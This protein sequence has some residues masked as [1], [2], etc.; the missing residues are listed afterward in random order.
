MT[1]QTNP[2]E[3]AGSWYVVQC[4]C[5]ME[6]YAEAFLRGTLG[7][8]TYLPTVVSRVH[9]VTKEIPF[10]PGYLFVNAALDEVKLS[11]INTTPGVVR[12]VEFGGE[13]CAVPAAVVSALKERLD[14]LK[15]QG[16]LP[17]HNFRLGDTV[18]VKRGPLAGLQAIFLGPTTPG[19]R[20][21]ILLEFLGRPNEV[22]VDVAA[23]TT[24][25]DQSR[26]RG[27][28]RTRGSGRSI[29]SVEGL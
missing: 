26:P 29:R 5:L 14:T 10:F 6:G 16:G 19:A 20:V 21:K 25:H 15:A 27:Q 8:L 1:S 17:G 7:I 13:R 24:V 4:R 23:L 9:G 28:R 3:G 18:S 2:S 12:L 22:E 11:S